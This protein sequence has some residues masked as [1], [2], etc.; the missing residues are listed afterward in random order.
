VLQNV[1]YARELIEAYY[2]CSIS[3][4]PFESDVTVAQT[5]IKLGAYANTRIAI[6]LANFGTAQVAISFSPA[7]TSTTGLIIPSNGTMS[8]VWNADFELVAR[9]IY[10]ISA[11]GNNSVHVIESVL[12]GL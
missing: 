5:V 6:Y 7:V 11:S 10:A 2:G 9:D 1:R 3:S 8:F 4:M 12:V